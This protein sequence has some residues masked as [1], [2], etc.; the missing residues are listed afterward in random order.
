MDPPTFAQSFFHP[1]SDKINSIL[2]QTHSGLQPA[3]C[4]Y[5]RKDFGA[6]KK[7]QLDFH[8][9]IKRME[10]LREKVNIDFRTVFYYVEN[11]VTVMDE[12]KEFKCCRGM[13]FIYLN[14]IL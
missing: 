5:S 14:N 9:C 1:F 10:Y 8:S 2:A 7:Y 13:F 3:F 11:D 6:C 4:I 12:K